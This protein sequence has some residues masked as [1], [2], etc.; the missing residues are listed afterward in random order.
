KKEGTESPVAPLYAIYKNCVTTCFSGV[1]K[2]PLLIK[3][4]YFDYLKAL[5]KKQA[6]DDLERKIRKKG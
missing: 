2:V 4:A 6:Q 1:V 3:C 5:E